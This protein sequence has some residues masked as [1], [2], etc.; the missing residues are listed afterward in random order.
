MAKA[1]DAIEAL[2]S[3][4]RKYVALN[5]QPWASYVQQADLL[6]IDQFLARLAP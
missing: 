3:L 1:A 2:L 5:E 4:A 6:Q